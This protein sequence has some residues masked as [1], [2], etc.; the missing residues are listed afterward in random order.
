MKFL[1]EFEYKLAGKSESTSATSAIYIIILMEVMRITRSRILAL[2][3][4]SYTCISV[5]RR[6]RRST[7]IRKIVRYVKKEEG[8]NRK[9]RAKGIY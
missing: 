6:V 8:I 7:R 3:G 4:C 5:L 9:R 1:M 2:A